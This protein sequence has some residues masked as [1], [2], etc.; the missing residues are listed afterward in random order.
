M[1]VKLSLFELM[2]LH[3]IRTLFPQKKS[4]NFTGSSGL[5]TLIMTLILHSSSPH[6]LGYSQTSSHSTSHVKPTKPHTCRWNP[7]TNKCDSYKSSYG[8][9]LDFVQQTADVE[10]NSWNKRR[11]FQIQTPIQCNQRTLNCKLQT[12]P[13]KFVD[14]AFDGHYPLKR[15][16]AHF[17]KWTLSHFPRTLVKIPVPYQCPFCTDTV[18][19]GHFSS[20]AVPDQYLW[21]PRGNSSQ[22][23]ISAGVPKQ[24]PAQL[25]G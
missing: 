18:P 16:N 14:E 8:D 15:V 20:P 1:T 9:S 6:P 24:Y 13:L 12:F 5:S 10:W 22:F 3:Y 2:L 21:V 7:Y 25:W 4:S 19:N 11:L 23:P 17:R